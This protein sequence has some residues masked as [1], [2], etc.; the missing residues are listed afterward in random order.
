MGEHVQIRALEHLAGSLG[1]PDLRTAV[2]TRDRPGPAHKAGVWSDDVVWLQVRGGLIIAKADVR[3][4]WSGEYGLGPD[5]LEREADD[6][7]LPESFWAGRPRYG[8]AVV[9]ALHRARW[10]EP[11]WAGPRSYAYEWIVLEDER[12]RASWLDPKSPPRGGEDLLRAFLA[13]RERSFAP[14]L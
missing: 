4:A 6:P 3:I 7:T 10:V 11:F 9:A 14:T 12:K 2:E 1:R 13:A 5:K 8:Y